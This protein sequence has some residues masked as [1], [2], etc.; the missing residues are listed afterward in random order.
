MRKPILHTFVFLI[1]CFFSTMSLAERPEALLEKTTAQM[2]DTMKA[3]SAQM[4][5]DPE[6]IIGIVDR[7]LVPHV[8]MMD[9][10]KWVV[11][12]H[13]WN[14][15][16][17]VQRQQF[18]KE[19]KYLMIRTYASTF[20]AYN[21]QK[22]QYLPIRGDIDG[23]SRVQVQSVIKEPGKESVRVAYRLVRKNGS[24]QVYDIIIEGVSILKG[25][26]SQFAPD[27]KTGGVA[28]AIQV[29]KLHNAKPLR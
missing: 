18:A 3:H 10:A 23:K 28:K 11:G 2:L 8:D 22:I 26:Q 27:I 5:R 6:Y 15:A 24:W 29:I 1:A 7:V 4:K 19:F 17:P 9:M 20:N 14:A 12:R 13:A 21:D 16:T 25:F